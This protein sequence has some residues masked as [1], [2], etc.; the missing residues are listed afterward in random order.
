MMLLAN[1][2]VLAVNLGVLGL[3]IKVYT[4]FI[5]EKKYRQP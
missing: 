1:L 2:L 5:K 3:T 4:E